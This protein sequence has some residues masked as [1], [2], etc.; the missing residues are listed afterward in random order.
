[1]KEGAY[2]LQRRWTGKNG[3]HAAVR[4]WFCEEVVRQMHPTSP[5]F[6]ILALVDEDGQGLERRRSEVADELRRLG[7]PQIAP[8]DG[9]C[10]VLPVRNAETWMVWANPWQCAGCP[11]SPTA[12]QAYESVSEV[13]DYK[14]WKGLNGDPLPRESIKSA[15]DVGKMIATLN[16]N[17]PPVGTPPALQEAL[18]QLS[19]FLCWARI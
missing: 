1:V 2:N 6:G 16:A 5:R 13:H 12:P 17:A 19:D 9:R 15:Y 11:T 7:L 14:R 4:K 3:N 18:R 8:E 10:L